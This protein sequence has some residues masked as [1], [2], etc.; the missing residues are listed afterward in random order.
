[1]SMKTILSAAALVLAASAVHAMDELDANG[2]GLITYDEMLAAVP[3]ATE[4]AF[5]LIDTNG[6]GALDAEE[7]AAA[8]QAGT[9]PIASDG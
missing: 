5:T 4:E 2:D 8:E 3:Q 9:L 7:Y 6:D 1:M